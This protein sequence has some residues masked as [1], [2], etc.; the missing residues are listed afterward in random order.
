MC[1]LDKKDNNAYLN[2]T[3]YSFNFQG[4]QKLSILESVYGRSW[5]GSI[6]REVMKYNATVSLNMKS[7][8]SWINISA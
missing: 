1:T 7:T 3:E 5:S 4:L 8:K 2:L 6:D